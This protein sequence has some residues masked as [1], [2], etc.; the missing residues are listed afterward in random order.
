M[1]R[2]QQIARLAEL[3]DLTATAENRELFDE[4]ADLLHAA[5]QNPPR[6]Y[7]SLC[8]N[9]DKFMFYKPKSKVNVTPNLAHGFELEITGDCDENEIGEVFSKWLNE[10]IS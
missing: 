7:V 9:A 1:R 8:M 10:E 4:Y 3:V 2:Y 5:V 6:H